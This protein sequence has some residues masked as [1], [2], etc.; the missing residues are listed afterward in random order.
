MEKETIESNVEHYPMECVLR[1]R[2]GDLESMIRKAKKEGHCVNSYLMF[3]HRGNGKYS[4][5]P[6]TQKQIEIANG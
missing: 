1:V 3:I 6:I 5:T 4:V 2:I